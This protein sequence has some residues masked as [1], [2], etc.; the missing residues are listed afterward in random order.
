[1]FDSRP[2]INDAISRDTSTDDVVAIDISSGVNSYD[3]NTDMYDISPDILNEISIDSIKSEDEFEISM[4]IDNEIP[5]NTT[6]ELSLNCNNKESNNSKYNCD[7]NY[8]GDIN[9]SIQKKEHY[10]HQEN[11]TNAE[12]NNVSFFKT[13]SFILNKRSVELPYC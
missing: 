10:S 12:E 6:H 4:N 11:E 5:I 7:L 8:N 9:N 1:M 13:L 2:S 3:S